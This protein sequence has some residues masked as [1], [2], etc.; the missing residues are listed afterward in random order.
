MRKVWLI[1][2][3]AAA[4]VATFVISST[5]GDPPGVH[6]RL[7]LYDGGKPADYLLQR[8]DV[9]VVALVYGID[10]PSRNESRV[11]FFNGTARGGSIYIPVAKLREWARR[12]AEWRRGDVKDFRTVLFITVAVV[13][14]TSHK[15]IYL[16]ID[17]IDISPAD[18]EMVN[19]YTIHME[20]GAR[21]V[22][23]V[24]KTQKPPPLI[25]T[26]TVA[27]YVATPEP[28]LE[29]ISEVLIYRV[30]TEDLAR[31][32]PSTYFKTADGKLYMKIPAVVAYNKYTYSGTIAISFRAVRTDVQFGIYPTFG[33]GD[34]LAEKLKNNILPSVTIWKG[35]VFSWGDRAVYSA[36]LTLDPERRGGYGFGEEWSLRAI[37]Y[38]IVPPL[39][40]VNISAI[41]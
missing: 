13:N 38:T 30:A 7:K 36:S 11:V 3:L 22:V 27:A 39:W 34:N 37:K 4:L 2:I 40:G 21:N 20:R 12:W 24:E 32:Y 35:N 1:G 23:K 19:I 17:N 16:V 10:P 28:T 9:S 6:I 18:I 25:P 5:V 15:P 33:F 14:K 41:R 26:G 29:Y 31:L 8:G